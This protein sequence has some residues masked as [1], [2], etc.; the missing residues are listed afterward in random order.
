MI[1]QKEK[2]IIHHW[3]T[4]GICSAA[5]LHNKH[6]TNITPKIGNYFL[7]E[8]EM[9]KIKK[10]DFKE[11]YVVDLALHENSLKALAEISHVKVFDHHLTKK[12]DGIEYINPI[13]EGKSEEDYPSASWILGEVLN[14]KDNILSF[15][16]A[17]GDW[18]ERLKNIKFYEKLKIFMEKADITFEEMHMMI[19][20][21]DSN[22]KIG[23]KEEVEK[24][25]GMLSETNDV[26][27]SILNNEKWRRNKEI[28]DKE[29]EKAL[30]GRGKRINNILIK[31]MNCK[32]NIISTVAR[33]LW[34]KK[35]YV[36]VINYGYFPNDCQ[37]YVR[38]N[39]CLNLIQMATEKKYIAGGKKNVMGAIVPKQ[40]CDEFLNEVIRVIR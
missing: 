3:D 4:D 13:L 26:T 1:L 23:N 14:K 38:G 40:E 6:T 19:S 17:V 32:Y 16:G 9:E 21:I 12:I 39:D 30:N 8:N 22:Y 5:L 35:N 31:E 27:A 10:G 18:E 28:I 24:A 2:L 7:E 15:L 36:I 11:I 29:I 33:K 37:V 25:V 20:L 34:D